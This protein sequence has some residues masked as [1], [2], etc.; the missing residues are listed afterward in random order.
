MLSQLTALGG[1]VS[2]PA[3]KKHGLESVESAS[4]RWGVHVSKTVL[5][6]SLLGAPDEPS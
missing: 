2:V 5:Y 3:L 6:A 1:S 4:A